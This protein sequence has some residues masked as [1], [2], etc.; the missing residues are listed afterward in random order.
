MEEILRDLYPNLND[1][2]GQ[3]ENIESSDVLFAHIF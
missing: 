3:N 1:F 2:G